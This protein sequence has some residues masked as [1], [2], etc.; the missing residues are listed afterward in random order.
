M[1]RGAKKGAHVGPSEGDLLERRAFDDRHLGSHRLPAQS[2]V[3]LARGV[4]LEDPYDHRPQPRLLEFGGDGEGEAAA[5]SPLLVGLKKV[6]RVKLA[7][8]VG[9]A[10]SV[11]PSIR[12]PDDS[13]SLFGDVGELSGIGDGALPQVLA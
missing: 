13:S 1:S 8:V 6:N 12:K 11:L 2:P 5:D 10:P 7:R 4:V 9:L 3:E